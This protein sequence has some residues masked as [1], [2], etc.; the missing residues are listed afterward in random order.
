MQRGSG[1]RHLLRVFTV[2]CASLADTSSRTRVTAPSMRQPAA[3]IQRVN[4]PIDTPA[5]HADAAD[6]VL[7]GAV[8]VG[9]YSTA[10]GIDPAKFLHGIHAPNVEPPGSTVSAVAHA[11]VRFRA[12]GQ[13]QRV[14]GIHAC[15]KRRARSLPGLKLRTSSSVFRAWNSSPRSLALIAWT[16][17]R[18]A[19]SSSSTRPSALVG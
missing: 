10:F 19:H 2:G 15:C 3:A 4:K 9:A 13:H 14:A 8:A 7:R 1:V 18:L 16:M 17:S 11:G 12:T 6:Q 5:V